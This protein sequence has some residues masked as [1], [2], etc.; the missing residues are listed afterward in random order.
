MQAARGTSVATRRL[1]LLFAGVAGTAY[2]V[3]QVSKVLAVEHLTGRDD[4][5]PVVGDLLTLHLVYNPGAAFS[6]GTGI[7]PVI[8]VVAILATL[9]VL[10][11]A[12]RIGDRVWAVALGLLLAGVVGNLTDRLLRDPGFLR[13]HVVDFLRLPNWP[14]FNVADICINIAAG[15]I[16]VQA[17]RGVRL[18]GTRD[19]DHE[20]DRSG[21][22]PD[23]QSDDQPAPVE[24]R[25]E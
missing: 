15:L 2:A 3:D 8:S 13:G 12:R 10:W 16:I 14:V 18:D 4:N 1:S 6:A 21:D 25:S 11:F 23:D 5:V 9:G 20:P 19:R 7:T 22:R 17:L 24:G